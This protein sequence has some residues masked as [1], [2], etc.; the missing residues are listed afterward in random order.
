M[1]CP[2]KVAWN[3]AWQCEWNT[4]WQYAWLIS[5]QTS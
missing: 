4:A 5:K 2:R 3:I 1:D